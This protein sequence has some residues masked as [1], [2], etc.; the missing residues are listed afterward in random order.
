[1]M[2]AAAEGM[3]S[4]V[5]TLFLMVSLQ[6]TFS[7]FHSV[8][9]FAMSSPTFFGANPSG[10]TFGARVAVA[11]DSPPIALT[12]TI[13]SSV[14]S[15]LGAI[16]SLGKKNDYFG[17][18]DDLELEERVWVHAGIEDN[19]SWGRI[20]QV[21]NSLDSSTSKYFY[22]SDLGRIA[23]QAAKEKKEE[24][25]LEEQSKIDHENGAS[26]K[27]YGLVDLAKRHVY[28]FKWEIKTNTGSGTRYYMLNR[29]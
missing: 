14:G 9:A 23:Y 25:Y 6:V 4:T 11:A 17:G 20:F 1:M 26:I 10:P 28:A 18:V 12:I 29:K 15:S 13:F 16:L 21:K 7:P 19:E 5:A 3:T 27:M 22:S 8:V 2:R 24:W